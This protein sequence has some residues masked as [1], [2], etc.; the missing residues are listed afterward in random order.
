M[1]NGKKLKKGLKGKGEGKEG[2]GVGKGLGT[3][4]QLEENT[5][6]TGLL[7]MAESDISPEK[8]IE[9][10]NFIAMLMKM[11]HSPETSPA[12]V[13]MLSAGEASEIVPNTA[14]TIV[15]QVEK[16]IGQATIPNDT[17]AAGAMYLVTDLCEIGNVAKLWKKDVVEEDLSGIIQNTLQEYLHQGMK[18]GTIDPVQLQGEIEPLLTEEQQMAGST[19]A[20]RKGLP[21]Q[22][23]EGMAYTKAAGDAAKP[24]EEENAALKQQVQ[25]QE[26]AP[27][28]P[29]Q[30]ALQGPPQG[31]PQQGGVQ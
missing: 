21:M 25:K 22:P 10:E 7:T 18:N 19:L 14:V 15:N 20:E 24:L 3:T 30:Q 23:T 6:T 31:Q 16:E 2:E 4:E 12:V 29:P 1:S 17:K 27:T 26:P 8:K 13:D 5:S 28:P 11:I 9:Y